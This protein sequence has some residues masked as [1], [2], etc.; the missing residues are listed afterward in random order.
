MRGLVVLGAAVGL[1]SACGGDGDQAADRPERPR[2]VTGTVELERPPAGAP[3]AG[4]SGGHHAPDAIASTSRTSLAVRG[5]VEPAHSRVL[6]RD[7]D[8]DGER[9][10]RVDPDGRF[11]VEASGLR[12]G[13]NAFVVQGRARGYRPWTIDVSITRR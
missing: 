9:A 8:T 5:K 6:I 1:L 3:D 7:R 12:R 2:I 4:T 11:V 13:P 10:A